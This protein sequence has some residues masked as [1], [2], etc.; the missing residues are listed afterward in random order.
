MH[1]LRWNVIHISAD[2]YSN[3]QCNRL[4]TRLVNEKP[5]LLW[6]RLGG[7]HAGSGNRRDAKRAGTICRLIRTQLDGQRL[8]LVDANARCTTWD[9]SM[10]S[11]CIG[12][13]VRVD[14]P[15]C[16][17]GFNASAVTRAVTNVAMSSFPPCQCSSRHPHL[18][19]LQDSFSMVYEKEVLRRLVHL[20]LAHRHGRPE[21]PQQVDG[22][23][24]VGAWETQQTFGGQAG[25]VQYQY[26][27]EQA[28]RAKLRKQQLKAAGVERSKP[29]SAKSVEQ[30]WDDCG[31]DTSSI[32]LF[33]SNCTDD[34]L[35]EPEFA[36][37]VSTFVSELF[38][39]ATPSTRSGLPQTR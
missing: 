11:E 12:N 8:F 36:D 4:C 17:F 5:S 33:G 22:T 29:A 7:P 35:L 31:E 10:V 13:Q 24:R 25:H 1:D 23:V 26:P 28:E 21:S 38:L 3:Q 27:T 2:L 15:W 19:E 39:S 14:V 30:H 37:D 16:S 32:T 34:G 9:L 18:R 20:L 6:I